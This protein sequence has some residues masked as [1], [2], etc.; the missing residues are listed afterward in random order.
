M[1]FLINQI[2]KEI[3]TCLKNE[4][5]IAALT[6]ALT[7]P[8]ICGKVEYPNDNTTSRYKKWY[9]KWIGEYERCSK[10]NDN[11][12]YSTADLIYDLRRSLLHEGNP[13]VD[14][15]RN[16]LMSFKLLITGSDMS[17]TIAIVH[18]DSNRKP[19][20]GEIQIGI[21]NL[22]FKLCSMAKEFYNENKDKFKFNY[23]I[24]KDV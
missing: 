13:N 10:N 22:C 5:Y 19:I 23:T 18:K 11:I 20:G 7:L 17:G 24:V 8:D 1:I 6:T 4:C 16:N 14:L 9:S 2:I 3:E 21:E 15:G 12:P